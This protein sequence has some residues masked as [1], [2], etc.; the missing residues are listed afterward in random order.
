MCVCVCVWEGV[1][2]GGAY[3]ASQTTV[4]HMKRLNQ[5]EYPILV[6]LCVICF[7]WQFFLTFSC[8][9]HTAWIGH[10]RVE[11]DFPSKT[12]ELFRKVLSFRIEKRD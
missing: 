9:H 3:A 11:S 5:S 4:L 12:G 10:L 6:I 2:V 1:G 8:L 7:Q